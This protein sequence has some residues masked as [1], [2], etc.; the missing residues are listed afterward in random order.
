MDLLDVLGIG[1]ELKGKVGR[2]FSL[3]GALLIFGWSQ[4]WPIAYPLVQAAYEGRI[5]QLTD[6]IT[7]AISS[8]SAHAG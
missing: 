6:A 3:V 2:C 5:E 8:K 4:R 7:R 1:S